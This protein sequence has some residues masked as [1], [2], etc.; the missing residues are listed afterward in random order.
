MTDGAAL[1]LALSDMVDALVRAGLVDVTLTAG[2]A[3]GGDLEAV[4]VPSALA[5]ARHA[6]M[7]DVVIVAMGPGVVGTVARSSTR[8]TSVVVPERQIASSRSYPRV[9]GSSVAV[10]ASVSPCPARSRSTAYDIAMN[11]EV[12]QPITATRSPGRGS[13]SRT[14]GSTSSACVQHSGWLVSSSST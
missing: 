4:T 7:A 10:H 12:P 9:A 5:L 6:A 2:H 11:Q 13:A 8:S 14:A 3:F 1:P